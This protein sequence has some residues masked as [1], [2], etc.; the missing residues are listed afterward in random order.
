MFGFL[1]K[2]KDAIAGVVTKKERKISKDLLEEVLLEADVSYE[3][4]ENAIYF[5]PAGEM[6]EKKKIF[7]EQANTKERSRLLYCYFKANAKRTCKAWNIT[8]KNYILA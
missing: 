5:L 8:E 7:L 3:V 4:V 2:T 6:V 1:K